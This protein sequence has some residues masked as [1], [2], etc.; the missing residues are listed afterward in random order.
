[1]GQKATHQL[2][3]VKAVVSQFETTVKNEHAVRM[4]KSDFI[5]RH[6]KELK[7]RRA[8]AAM[9]PNDDATSHE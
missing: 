5:E 9:D 6:V 3:E 8:L 4:F 2:E 7:R 1:V